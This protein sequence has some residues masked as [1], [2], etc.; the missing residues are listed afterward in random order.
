MKSIFTLRIAL[1]ALILLV[2]VAQATVT[3]RAWWLWV[4]ELG[5]CAASNIAIGNEI[6]GELDR[7]EITQQQWNNLQDQN[8]QQMQTCV[9]QINYPT[10]EPDFCDAARAARDNCLTQ[11]Y[12]LGMEFTEARMECVMASGINQCE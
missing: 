11:Y 4:D 9:T 12:G 8:M 1:V 3:T 6:N 10:Q 7:N 2:V 5:D